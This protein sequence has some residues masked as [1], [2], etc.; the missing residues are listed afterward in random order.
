MAAPNVHFRND[1]QQAENVARK[2]ANSEGSKALARVGY[3]AK[4]VVYLIIGGLAARAAIGIGGTTTDQHGAIQAI[5]KQPFGRFLLAIVTIGFFAFTLWSL[6]Q[7]VFDTEGKGTDAKGIATRIGYG[8]AGIIYLGLAITAL[9][10]VSGTGGSGKSSN[11]SAQ[12]WTARLLSAPGG[13]ALVVLVA[14]VMFGVTAAM[15]YRA[16]SAEFREHFVAMRANVKNA[17]LALGRIGYAA[18]G[19]VFAVVGI[20]LL[21]AGFQHNPGQAKGLSGA[22]QVVAQ[23]PFGHFLLALLAL[24]LFAYGIFSLAEARYRRIGNV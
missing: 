8:V 13:G 1:A 3:A 4:G 12:D 6:A 16:Y 5:Y 17:V 7:A 9:K 24:G 19:V 22:L 20:F 21:L 2:A 10:M 11:A 14:L 15:F 18:L 23:Q